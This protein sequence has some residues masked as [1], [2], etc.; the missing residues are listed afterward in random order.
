MCDSHDIFK[1]ARTRKIEIAIKQILCV[2][3]I[4]KFLLSINALMIH[5]GCIRVH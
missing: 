1:S 5:K 4:F 3:E 2:I